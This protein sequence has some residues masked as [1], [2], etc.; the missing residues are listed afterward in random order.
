M[1]DCNR[2][3][4]S[5]SPG[6]HEYFPDHDLTKSK[7]KIKVGEVKPISKQVNFIDSNSKNTTF[8]KE[9][10]QCPFGGSEKRFD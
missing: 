1:R 7:K 6:P 3:E 4:V 9:T 2:Y 5:K 8:G 10:R